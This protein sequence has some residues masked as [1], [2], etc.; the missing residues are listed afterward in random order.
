MRSDNH[1]PLAVGIASMV[2]VY[3]PEN[4]W[5]MAALVLA[6]PPVLILFLFFQRQFIAGM[7]A[8]GSLVEK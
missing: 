4:D 6:T 2:N 8:T 1:F 3:K 7:T 5:L